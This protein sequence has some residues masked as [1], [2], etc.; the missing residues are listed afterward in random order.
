M[1]AWWVQISHIELVHRKA[2][3][4]AQGWFQQGLER[5]GVPFWHCETLGGYCSWQRSC[6][7]DAMKRAVTADPWRS[8]HYWDFQITPQD[9]A[10][11]EFIRLLHGAF[12]MAW[13]SIQQAG[14]TQGICQALS[15]T[16]VI[17]RP[18][19]VLI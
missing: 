8:S 5:W 9:G 10:G 16:H 12:I 15:D 1:G 2:T 11:L 14:L 19:S 4:V 18:S 13:W 3:E 6:C 17:S 7:M